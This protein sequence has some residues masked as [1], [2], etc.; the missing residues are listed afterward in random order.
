[1]QSAD[2]KCCQGC[3]SLNFY[4]TWG[5]TSCQH[6]ADFIPSTVASSCLSLEICFDTSQKTAALHRTDSSQRSSYA[7]MFYSRIVG[8][9]QLRCVFTI[10]CITLAQLLFIR[11]DLKHSPRTLGEFEAYC[12]SAPDEKLHSQQ[13]RDDIWVAT[14]ASGLNA[15]W[16]CPHKNPATSHVI[17]SALLC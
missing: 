8:E 5:Y 3:F 10:P 9:K 17:S 6:Q 14:I 13:L 16:C 7:E 1:M 11:L 15:E 2:L 12:Q 4:S